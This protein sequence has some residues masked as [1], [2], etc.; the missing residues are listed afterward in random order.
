[1]SEQRWFMMGYML[2]I[3]Y[4]TVIL[5]ALLCYQQ[6]KQVRALRMA[7]ENQAGMLLAAHREK[8]KNGLPKE[9]QPER[10]A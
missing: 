6:E 1:M 9:D 3:L 4:M 10:Q 2:G 5:L 7:N 8:I